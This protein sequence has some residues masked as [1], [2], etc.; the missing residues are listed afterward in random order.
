MSEQ[1][2]PSL[3]PSPQEVLGEPPAPGLSRPQVAW[4]SVAGVVLLALTALVVVTTVIGA[5]DSGADT[6]PEDS[7]A[8]AAAHHQQEIDHALT[9]HEPSPE[10]EQAV[11]QAPPPPPEV[12][13]EQAPPAPATGAR[14][15]VLA[16]GA[17]VDVSW[18]GADATPGAQHGVKSAGAGDPA[19]SLELPAADPSELPGV[20]V[21]AQLQG[22]GEVTCRTTWA[23][24][25]VTTD[26]ASGQG[27]AVM[28]SL[29]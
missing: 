22:S 23:G 17:P 27:A 20:M 2:D 18:M 3:L 5:G 8:A 6:S 19:W 24:Q 12:E 13:A 7:A 10:L 25:Q 14:L 28:C 9:Y 21:M 29:T 16:S 1:P 11:E 26:T 4:W 15:E